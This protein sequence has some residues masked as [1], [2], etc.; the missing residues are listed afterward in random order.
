[1]C[2]SLVRKRFWSWLEIHLCS[3]KILIRKVENLQL[4]ILHFFKDYQSPRCTSFFLKYHTIMMLSLHISTASLLHRTWCLHRPSFQARWGWI[5]DACCAGAYEAWADVL[6]NQSWCCR[7][8]LYYR[9]ARGSFVGKQ[10]LIWSITSL[11]AQINC[12]TQLWTKSSIL[13]Q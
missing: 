2:R 5:S 3:H 8:H 13:I 6:S 9:P 1:M 11:L 7:C 12:S 10:D 4:M